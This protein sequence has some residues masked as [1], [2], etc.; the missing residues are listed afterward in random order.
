MTPGTALRLGRVSNL[1][2]IWTNALADL[3]LSAAMAEPGA[4]ALLIAGVSLAY[5]AGMFLNDAFDAEIDALERPDRPIPAG[6][7]ACAT[8]FAWGY[9]MLAASVVVIAAAGLTAGTG[10]RAAIAAVTLA[11]LI[12]VYDRH[13][14][15]N[16]LGPLVMASCRVAVYVAA[17]LVANAYLGKALAIGAAMLLCHLIAL[18]CIAKQER[19]PTFGA[20]WPIALLAV[21]P[22]HG[23]LLLARPVAALP[24]LA[25][26]VADVLAI[27]L[28][29]RRAPGDMPRA[30]MTLIAA[31]SLVDALAI[32]GTGRPGLALIAA[33]GFPLTLALQRRVRGT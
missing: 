3:V 10:A 18:T 27:G 17:A 13:H 11:V 23:V 8:V 14:K 22:V 29:R 7:V 20:L 28:L 21:P 32:A 26:L 4:T 9:A 25:L 6:E 24:W 2:T 31:I 12:I 16:P 15:A 30:V 5:A 33:C 1:P 19:P